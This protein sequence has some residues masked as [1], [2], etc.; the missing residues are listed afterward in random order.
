MPQR[1]ARALRNGS[2]A[3]TSGVVGRIGAG[4]RRFAAGDGA[5]KPA[6]SP[7]QRRPWRGSG[8]YAHVPPPPEVERAMADLRARF[9]ADKGGV[10]NMSTAERIL[11]D[12]AVAAA[13][14]HGRA[15][16]AACRTGLPLHYALRALSRHQPAA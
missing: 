13:F 15:G 5:M 16:D 4:A 10:E 2:A 12:L 6:A 11:V 7:P 1:Q 3:E 8:L 9:V 14:K